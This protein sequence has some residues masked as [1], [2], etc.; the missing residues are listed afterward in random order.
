MAKKILS[1]IKLK[2][3]AGK[4]NP[5]PPVGPM[6]GQYG[7]NLMEFCKDFNNRTKDISSDVLIPVDMTVYDDKSFVF[8]T[9]SPDTSYFL[10]RIVENTILPEDKMNYISVRQIYEIAKIKQQDLHLKH[11][12]LK[13]LCKMIIG[14]AKSMGLVV[15]K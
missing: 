4:A 15:T 2:I 12:T 3:P 8:I 5:A 13:S 14:T 11:L 6:L 9:K 10:R 1:S 7:L